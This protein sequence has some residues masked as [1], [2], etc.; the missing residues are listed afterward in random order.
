MAALP[1]LLLVGL[2][3]SA[4]AYAH[5]PLNLVEDVDLDRYQGTWYEIALLP[6]RFQRRCAANTRA[7]YRLLDNGRVEVTNRCQRADGR[8]IEA[9]GEARQAGDDLP[10]AA[11][12]VRFAPRWLSWLPMVWGEYRI[13]ALDDDYR[14][15]M[16][17]TEDRRFLWILARQP[18]L[19]QST[20]ESLVAKAKEQGFATDELTW[21]RHDKD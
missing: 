17:G 10:D 19:P 2:G 18:E 4:M 13:I 8:W 11:L 12:E 5:P 21:T 6:N 20:V 1:V 7:S 15:A 3:L 9:R 14:F 16:V